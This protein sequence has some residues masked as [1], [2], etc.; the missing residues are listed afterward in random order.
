M[1]LLSLGRDGEHVSHTVPNLLGLCPIDDRIEHGRD[2]NIKIGKEDMDMMG[3]VLA[4]P[5]SQEG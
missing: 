1:N 4:K 5:V 3:D 2:K